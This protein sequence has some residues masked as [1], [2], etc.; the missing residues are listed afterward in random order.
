MRENEN[1]CDK[2]HFDFL[3][4][5]V[6]AAGCRHACGRGYPSCSSPKHFRRQ[7]RNSQDLEKIVRHF[8]APLRMLPLDVSLYSHRS[9]NVFLRLH[10]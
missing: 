5:Q 10:V 6:N 1:D 8:K 7:I 3:S 9:Q 2:N 4:F